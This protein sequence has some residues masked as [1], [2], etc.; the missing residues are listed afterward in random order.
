LRPSNAARAAASIGALADELSRRI[1]ASF[2][3]LRHDAETRT[4]LDSEPEM[5]TITISDDDVV[6]T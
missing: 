2:S 6:K 3:F 1:R 5:F 4:L